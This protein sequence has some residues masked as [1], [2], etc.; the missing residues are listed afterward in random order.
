MPEKLSILRWKLGCK[1]KQEPSFRFYALYDRVY[2][3]D[4]LETAYK[5]VRKNKGSA[6]VDGIRF[7][8]IENAEGGVKAY[9]DG[10]Q[11][12]LKKRTYRSQPVRRVYIPKPN[13]KLR[14]LG[15]PC[16][17][18]RVVQMAVLL[19]IEPIFEADFLECSHG[20]RPGR[21]A[22]DAL[23]QIRASIKAGRVNIYDA[24]LSSYFDMVDHDKLMD[25][26]TRR[27]TDRSVLKLIR[28]WLKS[29]VIED[30]GQ[31][32]K[33][34]TKPRRGTPQGGVI[35]PLLSNIYLHELDRAFYH[36]KN[37]PYRFANARLVRYADDYVVLARYMGSKIVGWIETKLEQDLNLRIN[38]EKTGIVKMTETGSSL[39]FLGF[40]MRYDRDLKG[41]AE[42]YL[43]VMPSRRAEA[44]LREKIREKTR[45]RYKKPLNNVIEEMN[46]ITRGWKNY[47]GYGYPR[48]SFRDM[49]H[50]MRCRFR[51]FLRNRSQRRSNPLMD[52]ESLYAA[53]KR[54]GL[55]Y[56]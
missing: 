2:R 13:G 12:A 5:R 56:L 53:L 22:H 42:K 11:E 3:R 45:S 48:K 51:S 55:V 44:R 8:E 29:P 39:D 46:Q 52:G 35:S 18:D 43:N 19:I 6:G 38:R 24:D 26:L 33:R 31:E 1:A 16:I 14:P 40:T 21:K 23:D 41:R 4:T 7:E 9:I 10:I 25:Q 15:I 36:D 27:I 37:S 34:V 47:F 54:R 17:R 28:M 30:D 32:G 49:S 50:F 20:F